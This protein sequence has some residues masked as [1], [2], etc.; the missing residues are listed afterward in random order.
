MPEFD[1]RNSVLPFNKAWSFKSSVVA[2]VY[3]GQEHRTSVS[4]ARRKAFSVGLVCRT[5]MELV[6]AGGSNVAN[7]SR[8]PFDRWVF[9]EACSW[10][11]GIAATVVIMM[12]RW[13][14]MIIQDQTFPWNK[15]CMLLYADKI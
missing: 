4:K 7:N 5:R 2:R 12:Q 10:T 3:G 11:M 8:I 13:L 14:M 15:C 1:S 6:E 9:K